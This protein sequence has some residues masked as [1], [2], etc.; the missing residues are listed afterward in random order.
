MER[1]IMNNIEK[2]A[3]LPEILILLHMSSKSA[4]H[5]GHLPVRSAAL[6]L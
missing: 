5:P 4:D 2:L 6:I 1:T 3:S